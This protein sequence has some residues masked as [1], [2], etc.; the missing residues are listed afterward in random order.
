MKTEKRLGQAENE[1]KLSEIQL[2]KWEEKRF[3]ETMKLY[4]ETGII[5]E[6]RLVPYGLE[7]EEEEP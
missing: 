5:D 1:P 7:Y 4:E 3:K 6:S 2:K